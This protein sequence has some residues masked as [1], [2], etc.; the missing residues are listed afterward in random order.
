MKPA[1]VFSDLMSRGRAFQSF[2]AAYVKE[3]LPRVTLDNFL[4]QLMRRLSRELLSLYRGGDLMAIKKATYAGAKRLRALNVI[5]RILNAIRN[6]TGSQCKLK[7]RGVIWQYVLR[8]KTS[9]AAAF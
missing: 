8:W 4:G 3:R 2:G 1:I 6:L 9:L 5:K 7:C